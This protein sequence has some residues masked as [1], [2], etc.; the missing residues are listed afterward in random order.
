MAIRLSELAAQLGLRRIGPDKD[1]A[2]VATLA[3]A[4][5]DQVAF[6]SN[7]R[8]AG[9]L[10]SSRAGCVLTDERHAGLVACALVSANVEYDWARLVQRFFARAQGGLAGIS[11]Q[12][13]VHP[14]A[15]LDPTAAVYPFAYIGPRAVLGSGCAVFPGCYVG[16]DCVLGSGC[17]LYP[18]VTLMAGTRL[19]DNVTVQPGAVL[20]GDGF[21]FAQ[22]PAGHLKKP[23]LG[24]VEIASDVEIGA[25]TTIDRAS[26][27]A[28]RVG[29]GSKID[30]LVQIAHNVEIGRHC[31]IVS[32]A[33]IAGSTAL[34][35]GVV[36]A[37]QVG[38]VDNVTIG[39]G[40]MAGAQAGINRDLKPGAR[41]GGSPCREYE[42]Y[43]KI[44]AS[45][46]RLPELLRRVRRLE[47]LLAAQGIDP[48]SE[49]DKGGDDGA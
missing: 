45:L 42:E 24:C 11:P 6:L 3:K 8:F 16:E 25:N 19:G 12:A 9:L 33:G 4:G 10:A 23:Q 44:S 41:V 37:G 17:T 1:I 46:P 26:L 13:F 38:I 47:K 49:P 43:L 5:P 30:N 18:N 48:D 35:H 14:E 29:Q 39:D 27:D 7:P 20:G 21:G 32:Q 36:L 28:T 40:V 34:G 2:G 31:L 15:R 22:G